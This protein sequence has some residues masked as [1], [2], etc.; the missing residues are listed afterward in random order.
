[1]SNSILIYQ[2][3]N[4]TPRTEVVLQ[5]ESVWLTQKST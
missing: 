5:N 4:G 3:E 2:T 1:M